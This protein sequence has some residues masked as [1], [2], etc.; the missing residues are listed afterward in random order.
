MRT[1][2]L[3]KS[4]FY[5]GNLII[6]NKTHPIV[7]KNRNEKSFLVPVDLRHSNILLELKVAIMLSKLVQELSCKDSIVPVS[8][9]RSLNEQKQ[10]YTDSLRENGTDFTT[11][12]I[13]LPD[14][15][16]HQTGLAIDL[17]ENG[18]HIDFIRPHFPYTGIC[19]SFRKRSVSY[20]FIERYPE[21]KE[22]I[23]GIAHEPWHF[24]YVGYPHAEIIQNNRLTLEEYIEYIKGYPYKGEHL[25]FNDANYNIEIFYVSDHRQSKIMVELPEDIPYQVSG[26]NVNGF[27]IT[28][29][30]KNSKKFVRKGEL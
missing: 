9:Y 8:G 2:I 22:Q 1:L 20:G 25:M 6:V 4:G 26:N 3:E 14:R 12:Y 10:L 16:E 7:Y 5:N 23:T 13:A 21:G 17:A 29:W 19:N 11:K 18:N 28:M 27:I 15:S 24:R 30:R